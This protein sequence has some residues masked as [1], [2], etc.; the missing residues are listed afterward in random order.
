MVLYIHMEIMIMIMDM[1]SINIQL[2]MGEININIQLTM[3]K[4]TKIV[5]NFSYFNIFINLA[6][7]DHDTDLNKGLLSGKIINFL[8]FLIKLIRS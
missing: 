2:T 6:N 3:E 4:K 5:K 1:E 7:L 8:T